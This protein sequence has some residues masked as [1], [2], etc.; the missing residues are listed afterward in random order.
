MNENKSANVF[1]PAGQKNN[2]TERIGKKEG[3]RNWWGH[4]DWV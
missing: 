2:E 1:I 3:P 4:R